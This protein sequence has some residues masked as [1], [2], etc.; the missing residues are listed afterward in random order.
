MRSASLAAGDSKK[1]LAV[2]ACHLCNNGKQTIFQ[3]LKVKKRPQGVLTKRMLSLGRPQGD[4]AMN[5]AMNASMKIKTAPP[6]GNTK[7]IKGTMDSTTSSSGC[8]A[9][10]WSDMVASLGSKLKAILR[11]PC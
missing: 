8:G 7:C 2:A 11:H 3:S 9:G 6:I 10:E 5:I 1:K 4:Q